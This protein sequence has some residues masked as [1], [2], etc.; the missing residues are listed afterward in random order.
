MGC[1]QPTKDL[2]TS[3]RVHE[4]KK[5]LTSTCAVSGMSWWLAT[6]DLRVTEVRST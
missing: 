3:G 2:S 6:F 4:E 1:C 5:T